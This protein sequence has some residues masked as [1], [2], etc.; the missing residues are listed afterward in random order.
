MTALTRTPL[1]FKAERTI[2]C[3][4]V[5]VLFGESA[6]LDTRI[7]L[8]RNPHPAVDLEKWQVTVNLL[9]EMYDAASA[10]IVQYRQDEFNAV[11]T[12][13]NESNFLERDVTWPWEMK[14]FCRRIIETGQPLYIE[15]ATVESEWSCYP[16]VE[17]GLICSYYGLPIHWPNNEPFGTLCVIDHKPTVYNSVLVRLLEQ[18]RDYVNADLK[19]MENFEHIR[20]LAM[21]DELTQVF[22][23][24]GILT[25]GEQRIK[26]AQRFDQDLAIIYFDIDNLKQTND[27]YGHD[28][29][30]RGLQLFT[31]I[32]KANSRDADLIARMGG[33]EFVMMLLTSDPLFIPTFCDRVVSEYAKVTDTEEGLRSLGISY[34]YKFFSSGSVLSLSE[35]IDQA[36]LLMLQQ[37]QLKK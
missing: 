5:T 11:V 3:Y 9:A 23:R 35:M 21:T 15:N 30:D 7:C 33:D 8:S 34:G 17:E 31:D 12:S 19:C 20:S 1:C 2:L 22:N 14:S 16:V 25:V 37:K 26:D 24:R 29:G 28:F 36:D 27:K 18:F 10:T 32:L 6:V 13:A 4:V